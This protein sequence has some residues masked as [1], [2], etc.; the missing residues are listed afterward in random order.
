MTVGPRARDREDARYL[1]IALAIADHGA[2]TRIDE[3]LAQ[4]FRRVAFNLV[5][6]HRD[7]H[8]RN[9]GFLRTAEGWRLAPAFDL[10][11][12]PQKPEHELSLDGAVRRGDLDVLRATASFYRLSES[13]AERIVDQ[14]GAAVAA[15][16]EAT[17]GAGLGSV[18]LDVL[19]EA[20]GARP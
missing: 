16:R 19:E 4:L 20:I 10:N 12:T 6:S 5:A 3:D 14:V 11:P 8:L 9:H 13:A 17:R 18:E 1:D 7:D 2:P 15:W